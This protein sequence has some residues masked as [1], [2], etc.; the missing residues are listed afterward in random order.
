[1][2]QRN[3]IARAASKPPAFPAWVGKCGL[4]SLLIFAPGCLNSEPP[5]SV[6]R[7][8][9]AATE[10]AQLAERVDQILDYTLKRRRLNTDTQAAWQIL[11]GVLA[12]GKNFPVDH[13]ES[14]SGVVDFLQRGGNIRG[15]ELQPGRILDES[16]ER[17]GLVAVMQP[18]TKA[19]QGHHD[20]WLAILAQ[21]GLTLTDTILADGQKFTVS[22]FVEQVKWDVPRNLNQEY[23]WTLIGLTEY[24][25]TTTFWTAADGETWSIERLV[26]VETDYGLGD[27][28][29]GGTH[30]LIGL[31]MALNKRRREGAP[32]EG[33]WLDAADLV[34][35]AL[36][37]A[38]R[39]QNQDG[40]FSTNYLSRGGTSQDLAQNL[41]TTGH[42]VEF[43]AIAMPEREI[44]A[45]WMMAAVRN[46]CDLFDKTKDYDLECG[47]LYH[48][49][50][51]L[52][53]YRNRMQPETPYQA[54]SPIQSRSP[55]GLLSVQRD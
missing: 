13:G 35:R 43:L 31:A 17:R 28:P 26:E 11:H 55:S 12:Y 10:V 27:G 30:R 19:G 29:C 8:Q 45:P 38:R 37:N 51:G 48:A 32:V 39:F 47:A 40:S 1:M 44:Q 49:A 15:F 34:E 7:P 5:R 18:G 25:P 54:Q 41:G 2:S 14:T 23:S 22:D 3:R 4:L 52:V 24:Y 16:S 46:L 42:L 9:T 21:S 33:V 6:A 53:L 50:H 36:V 20:Q